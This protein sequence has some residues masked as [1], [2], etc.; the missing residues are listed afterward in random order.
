MFAGGVRKPDQQIQGEGAKEGILDIRGVKDQG[1]GARVGIIDIRRVKEFFV[2]A[3]R[4][5]RLICICI[6]VFHPL[7][8]SPSVIIRIRQ[9]AP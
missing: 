1:G 2:M 6:K 3:S 5:C 8:I 9:N 7:C 4:R